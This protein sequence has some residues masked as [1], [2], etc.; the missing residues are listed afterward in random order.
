[1]QTN[2]ISIS[3]TDSQRKQIHKLVNDGANMQQ[4]AAKFSE[5][6]KNQI[7]EFV[8]YLWKVRRESGFSRRTRGFSSFDY[9]DS[10]A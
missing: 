8:C 2:V 9:E 6:R 4:I 3:L 5:A 7:K 1:M 10:S